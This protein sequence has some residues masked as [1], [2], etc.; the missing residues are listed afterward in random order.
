M[1]LMNEIENV[2]C[3]AKNKKQNQAS[4]NDF[5]D[6]ICIFENVSVRKEDQKHYK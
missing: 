2:K 3:I 1:N 6:R 4:F 5:I